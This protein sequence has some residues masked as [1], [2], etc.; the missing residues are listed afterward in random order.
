MFVE[1]TEPYSSQL[2]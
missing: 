1:H 2:L